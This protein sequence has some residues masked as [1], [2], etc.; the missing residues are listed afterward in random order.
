MDLLD[1]RHFGRQGNP[2]VELWPT[3]LRYRLAILVVFLATVA[4]AY[5]VVEFVLWERYESRANLLLKL[6]RE[7]AEVPSTVQNSALFTSGIREQEV[8]S[9]TF[10]LTSR[11]VV[12]QVVDR[13]GVQAFKFD[14]APPQTVWQYVK[15]GAK[16]TARWVKARFSS[17]LILMNLKKELDDREKAILAVDSSLDVAAEK[18]SD[19]IAVRV[20]LPSPDLAVQVNQAL[21]D[22]FFE[23]YV[24]LHRS[25]ESLEF[26][27]AQTTQLKGVLE[28]LEKKREQLRSTSGISAAK[29]QRTLLLARRSEAAHQIDQNEADKLALVQQQ[30]V[31][32][33]RLSALPEQLERSSVS[34][35]GSQY[36]RSQASSVTSETNPVRETFR[37]SV[38]EIDAKIA[39]LDAGTAKQR[40]IARSIDRDVARLDAAEDQLD[41]INRER[42]MAEAS[43]LTYSKRREE[44][45]IRE[46]LD[47][48][49]VANIVLMSP[50]S[51]P[52]EPVAPKK[53]LIMGIALVVGMLLGVG[54]A[55]LLEYFRD[56]VDSP[57]DLA[58]LDG[59]M[60]LGTFEPEAGPGEPRPASPA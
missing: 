10:M 17:L 23:K 39:G 30:R 14:P 18:D 51:R 26:F 34:T 27:E 47:D 31:M 58:S 13:V 60:L 1:N 54:L 11:D 15:Y 6:G 7:N 22:I 19:V 48:R 43:Y 24:R 40:E 32:R 57:R 50:P 36:R 35:P 53:L 28:G 56:T 8:K 38:E 33:E 37:R 3:L 45:R 46:A 49:H 21:L 59:M 9:I 12:G 42:T 16:V 25:E 52:A 20:G 41:A 4:S 29:E 2:W 55:L 44:A 5:V